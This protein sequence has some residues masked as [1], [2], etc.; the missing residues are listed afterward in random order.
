MHSALAYPDLVS[1]AAGFVDLDSLPVMETKGAIDAVLGEAWSGRRALQYGTTAGDHELRTHLLGLLDRTE[2][3]QGWRSADVL[4]R[5]VVTNG[6]SQVLYLTLE[7]LLD[8]GDLVIVE[9]PTYFVF[10][11]MAQ[12]RGANVV[13]VATDDGGM[14]IDALER[15]LESIEAR[16]DLGRLKLIYTISEHANPSGVTLAAD[17]RSRLVETVR[18]WSQRRGGPIYILEDAAYRGLTFEGGESPSIWSHD[19][20]GDTVILA[21][22]FSKTL[23]PGL[24]LGWGI[25]PGELAEAVRDLKGNHDF[26]TSNFVQTVVSKLVGDGVYERHIEALKPVYRRKR[27]VMLES[28]DRYFGGFEGVSWTRPRGGLFVWLTMPE[29][30]DSSIDGPFYQRCLEEGV[31]YV[32]GELAMAD[33]PGPAP[34]NHARLCFGVGDERQLIEGTRRLATALGACL[35]LV[36]AGKEVV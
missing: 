33:E 2:G 21:R 12:T 29:G 24:K 32:P 36:V 28:L 25:W 17:R 20:A 14:R 6:S 31:L 19:A 1:L 34:R 3:G 22:S 13:G 35:D 16:G 18:T 4:P 8:P 5:L 26:G 10:L 23:S 27:D 7:A 15:T 11:G 9:T 30:L